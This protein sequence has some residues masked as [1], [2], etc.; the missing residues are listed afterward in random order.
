[1]RKTM[2]VAPLAVVAFTAT[3]GL[4][5]AG[6]VTY[7]GCH[8]PAGQALGTSGLQ[9]LSAGN[10][11]ATTTGAG[12]SGTGAN[13]GLRLAFTSSAPGTGSAASWRIVPPG[14]VRLTTAAAQRTLGGFGG[15]GTPGLYRFGSASG[16]LLEE[17]QTTSAAA[18]TATA[19]GVAAGPFAEASLGCEAG[20]PTTCGGAG[21]V[22]D[23]ASLSVTV[24]DDNAPDGAVGGL[25]EP[26]RNV[27]TFGAT[28]SDQGAGL[29][30]ADLFVDGVLRQSVDLA[31]ACT[32][33]GPARP[34]KD[35]PAG[36]ACPTTASPSFSFDTRTVADGQH[37]FVLRLTDLSG[38]V[39]TILDRDVRIDNSPAVN[40]LPDGS[41]LG[42][43]LPLT[44]DPGRCLVPRLTVRLSQQPVGRTSSGAAIFAKGKR[45]RFRGTLTCR[46]RGKRVVAPAG[47]A[48]EV[49]N[50]VRGRFAAKSG[51]TVRQRGAIT[52][53]NPTNYSTRTIRFRYVPSTGNAARVNIPIV[54][55]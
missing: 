51:A 18:G 11:T 37:R 2:I 5:Q 42:Q 6:T 10:A 53:F 35:L 27:M 12:C 23:L 46:D 15:S 43:A 14:G 1:M 49:L 34:G 7:W 26:A 36:V 16:S 3:T 55:R 39:S 13:D 40:R 9:A 20:F 22:V 31:G 30:R 47:T 45:Y 24:S 38:N 50:I 44:A 8:G 52:W 19:S 32:D 17:V 25:G 33:I 21:A 4:A 48:V 28:T 54:V 41:V 29:E